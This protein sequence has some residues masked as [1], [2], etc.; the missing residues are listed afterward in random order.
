ML[1]GG[2]QV[3][4]AIPHLVAGVPDDVVDDPLIKAAGRHSGWMKKGP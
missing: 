1:D 2:H 3:P 4:V